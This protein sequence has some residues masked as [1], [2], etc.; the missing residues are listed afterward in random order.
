MDKGFAA[1]IGTVDRDF[2]GVPVGGRD[3]AHFVV[4]VDPHIHGVS[5]E[6]PRKILQGKG[7]PFGQ[8]GS[9]GDEHGVLGAIIDDEAQAVVGHDDVDGLV[10]LILIEVPHLVKLLRQRMEKL[11]IDLRGHQIVLDQGLLAVAALAI[12]HHAGRLV[13]RQI[14][15]V[16]KVFGGGNEHLFAL[17]GDPQHHEE[18]HHRGDKV[19]VGHLPGTAVMS[20]FFAH[21]WIV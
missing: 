17:S 1:D 9:A 20:A 2:P 10:V 7:A 12:H 14:E 21:R 11:H 19:R 4:G 13:E 16:G 6:Q 18:R 5:V 8:L 3:G 15:G